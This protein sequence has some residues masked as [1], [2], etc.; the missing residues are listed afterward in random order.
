MKQINSKRKIDGKI[1]TLEEHL[2]DRVSASVAQV[3]WWCEGFRCCIEV[4]PEEKLY[5]VWVGPKRVRQVRLLP[6]EKVRRRRGNIPRVRRV[7]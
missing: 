7:A 4:V 3:E 1:F 6:G 5:Y 2:G